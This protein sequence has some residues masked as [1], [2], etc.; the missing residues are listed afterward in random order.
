MK[1][2]LNTLLGKT[3]ERKERVP[4]RISSLLRSSFEPEIYLIRIRSTY[5]S[6]VM[7]DKNPPG[8]QNRE[9][10]AF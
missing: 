2:H 10:D 9:Q 5:Q 7:F 6:L 3:E 4:V 8:V 1:C